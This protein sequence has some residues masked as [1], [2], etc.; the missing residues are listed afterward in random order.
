MRYFAIVLM[1][2]LAVAACGDSTAAD[3]ER[4]CEILVEIDTQNTDGLPF[5][6]A[7]PIIVDGRARFEEVKEVAP[8]EIGADAGMVA[9]G[10]IRITDLLIAAGG[11]ETQI[12]E[13][14]LQ[15]V[16]GEVFTPEYEAATQSVAAWRV[17]NCA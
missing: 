17:A 9:D 8:E 6:E 14:E 1:L 15:L 5:E 11:D 16:V 10:A 7:L 13:A 2:A 4:F 3:P 12:D